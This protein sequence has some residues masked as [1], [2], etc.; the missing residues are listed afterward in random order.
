MYSRE[1]ILRGDS[2]GLLDIAANF[3]AYWLRVIQQDSGLDFLTAEEY[4]VLIKWCDV[5][6]QHLP[7]TQKLIAFLK[8]WLSG[9]GFWFTLTWLIQYYKTELS[10]MLI[11]WSSF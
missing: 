8:S 10:P 2:I 5:V 1:R 4:P 7:P 11:A 3:I 9:N 6:K